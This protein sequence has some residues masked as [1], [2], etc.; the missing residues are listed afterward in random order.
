MDPFTILVKPAGADCNLNCAYCFYAV[1][2][3][4]YP[5]T[6]THR[7]SN[8][9]LD[10]LIRSYM[11]T[12]QPQYAFAWQGGEPTLMGTD[13]FRRV[14][15]LQQRYGRPG[16]SVGNALQTNA[17]LLDDAMA[18]HFRKYNFLLGV[19]LDGPPELH[20]R[21][22]LTHDGRATH[23]QVLDGIDCLRRNKA[24]FNILTLVSA[25]NVRHGKETYRY[26]RDQG[27]LFHQYIPCVEMDPAGNP[28][29]FSISGREWGDFLCAVFDAW[30]K[31]D[32][33]TVSVRLFDGALSCL[34]G[35]PPTLCHMDRQCAQYYVVEHNGDVYPC[36]FFVD[37]ALKLGNIMTDSWETLARSPVRHRFMHMKSEWHPCCA[38]C[39]HLALCAG[40]CLKHR[41]Q[42]GAS[43][44]RL[45]SLCA[46]WRQFYDHA[47][48]DLRQL[49][50]VVEEER[51]AAWISSRG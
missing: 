51:R 29:P 9:V 45:S 7:M 16:S 31:N 48:K 32:V 6:A 26:L 18:E 22:R 49:A 12:P 43:P 2:S 8:E 13:F 44:D 10:R 33:R 36:D 47:L 34:T 35:G 27:F 28:L 4:L 38:K 17:T 15:D 40:D 50:A 30:I 20:D 5:T 1:K 42:R 46:G 3:G 37:P 41:L 14:T 21:F 11:E 39:R 19:S 23:R 25:A 24:E